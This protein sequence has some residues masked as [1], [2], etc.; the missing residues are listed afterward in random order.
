MLL[1][2]RL[3]AEVKSINTK[4]PPARSGYEH[5]RERYHGRI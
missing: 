5:T 3:G 1:P 2:G 4:R